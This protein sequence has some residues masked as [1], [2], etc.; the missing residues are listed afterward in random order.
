MPHE[1]LPILGVGAGGHP[2]FLTP[3]TG[4]SPLWV[5]WRLPLTTQAL[6]HRP[7]GFPAWS[8]YYAATPGLGLAVLAHMD[9]GGKTAA[10]IAPC[11]QHCP[12][13]SSRTSSWGSQ[14]TR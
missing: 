5:L 4:A 9:A 2:N 7:E 14:N 6:G 8:Q 3:G 13:A 11:G 1:R 12:A 10:H